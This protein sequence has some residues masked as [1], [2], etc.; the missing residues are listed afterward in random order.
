MVDIYVNDDLFIP[1]F[2]FRAATP[3]DNVPAEVNLNIG[4]APGN[5]S[6][7]E[8]IIADFDVTLAD[9]Q[10]YVVIANGVLDP[11]M[12]ADNP[13]G[14]NVGFSLYPMDNIVESAGMDMVK[15][16]GFHGATDAPAVDIYPLYTDLSYGEY[17]EY[18]EVPADVYTLEIRPSGCAPRGR[19]SRTCVS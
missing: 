2:A 8:D 11:M 18:A 7:P 10:T 14:L 6:G 1:D 3:F 5:S 4:V 15:V 19:P 17:S 12:F 13:D 9:N 16:I